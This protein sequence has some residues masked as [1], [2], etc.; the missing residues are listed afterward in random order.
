MPND[1]SESA[2]IA[3]IMAG[4]KGGSLNKGMTRPP[5]LTFTDGWP[6]GSRVAFPG[7][8]GFKTGTPTTPWFGRR[9]NP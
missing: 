8:K 1:Y 6:E 5:K 9:G 4:V 7:S 2:N 3:R